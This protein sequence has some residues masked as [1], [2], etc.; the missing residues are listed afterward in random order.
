MALKDNPKYQKAEEKTDSFLGN[1]AASPWT[2]IKIIIIACILLALGFCAGSVLADGG[3]H[4]PQSTWSSIA[5]TVASDFD[6]NNEVTNTSSATATS[7]GGSTSQSVKAYAGGSTGL[8]STAPCL[9]SV[10]I[11]FNA[12]SAT[13]V[14]EGCV[15][16]M[17]RETCKDDACRH[18]LTCL[19]PDLPD[20]AKAALG[21]K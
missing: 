20:P 1:L 3:K 5:T 21:C 6:N 11:L 13:V 4:K 19:D 9:G 10:G 18:A 17:Y 2:V 8:T 16:R 14:Q 7:S 15:I 12:I